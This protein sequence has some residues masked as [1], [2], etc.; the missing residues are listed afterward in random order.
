MLDKNQAIYKRLGQ[1]QKLY[2]EELTLS[3]KSNAD[4]SLRAYQSG[5][6]D[7][8]VLM[9]SKITELDVKLAG[10]RVRVDRARAQARLLY[11]TGEGTGEAY[12][13]DDNIGDPK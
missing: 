11:L 6:T 8:T 1:R 4:A 9:R 3:A 5:V 2:Q 13:G 12:T 10:L 7:F